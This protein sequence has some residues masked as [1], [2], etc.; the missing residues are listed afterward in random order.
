MGRH[1]YAPVVRFVAAID[2]QAWT[3]S[4]PCTGCVCYGPGATIDSVVVVIRRLLAEHA[5]DMQRRRE[6]GEEL[7]QALEETEAERMVREGHAQGVALAQAFD[8]GRL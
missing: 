8:T 2:T 3:E 5:R 7:P 4:G 6:R 1:S